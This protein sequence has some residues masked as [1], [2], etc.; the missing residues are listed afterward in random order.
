MALKYLYR[1]SQENQNHMKIK[2]AIGCHALEKEQLFT[3][4]LN[5]TFGLVK[6]CEML[7]TFQIRSVIR[8]L[9]VP[10]VGIHLKTKHK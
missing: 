2:Q 6:R 7:N 3:I 8:N 5:G 10:I 9:S 1:L 4:V